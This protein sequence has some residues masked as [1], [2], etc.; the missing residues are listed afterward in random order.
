GDL[1]ILT[2]RDRCEAGPQALAALARPFDLEQGPP[3][4][5]WLQQLGQEEHI[6]RVEMHHIVTDGWSIGIFFR[7]LVV[8]YQALSAGALPDMPALPLQYPDHARRQIAELETPALGEHIDYWRLRLAGV[9]TL[10]LPLDHRRP[11]APSYRGATVSRVLAA[12]RSE[13]VRQLARQEN[14]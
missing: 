12:G 4:R 9:P 7:E 3:M 11:P 13:A 8:F 1:E 10:Q 2:C 6:L 14:V 5:A